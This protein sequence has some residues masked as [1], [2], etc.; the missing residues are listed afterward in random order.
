MTHDEMLKE[1]IDGKGPGSQLWRL[2]ERLDIQHHPDCSC[3][4]LADIM[5]DLGAEGCREQKTILL[6]LMRKNQ[7][8]YGWHDALKAAKNVI[9]LGWLFKINPLDPLSSLLDEAIKLSEIK[10]QA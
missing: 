4:L 1:V 5:N 6:K 7:K 2:F 9:V 10:E 8:K 3:L